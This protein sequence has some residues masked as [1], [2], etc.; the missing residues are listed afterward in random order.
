MQ[1]SQLLADVGL[2]LVQ[3]SQ[4]QA[5][6][7]LVQSEVPDFSLKALAPSPAVPGP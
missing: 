3:T 2:V 6:A 5:H 7:G 4:L 1:T